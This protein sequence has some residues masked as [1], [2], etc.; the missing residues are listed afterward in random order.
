MV[1]VSGI[2]GEVGKDIKAE[3][4]LKW[5]SKFKKYIK[6]DTFVIG[7]D[8]R[9]S[10]ETFYSAVL[11]SFIEK[12]AKVYASGVISTP[13]AVYLSKNLKAAG[14]VITASHNPANW[15]GIK[16]IH[17]EG[18]FLYKEEIEELLKT[19]EEKK[20][21][22]GIEIP[23]NGASLH[24]EAVIEHS[25]IEKKGKKFKV[26]IDPVNGAS[27]YEA[28]RVVEELGFK[29]V[30][31][32]DVPHGN[33]TRPPEPIPENLNSL[34]ELIKD[35]K[36]D[37]GFAFDPD[38]DRVSVV[39]EDGTPLG[40]EFTFPLCYFYLLQR[41]KINAVIN[42]S[43]SMIAE[44]IAQ[45]YGRKVKRAPVGEVNV[46]KKM[47]EEEIKVGG[48]G[49]G[50]LIFSPFNKTRDGIFAMALILSLKRKYGEIKEVVKGFPSY[51]MVKKKI[52]RRKDINKIKEKLIEEFSYT[53]ISLEDGVWLKRE[54]CFIHVRKS[55]TEP[56]IRVIIEGKDKKE[57]EEYEKKVMKICVE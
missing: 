37:I 51:F 30:M 18:R 27:G 46:L 20:K 12:N 2:R 43:T 22:F 21:G 26:A 56:V 49:N 1:S 55:N 3:D 14:F 32:N 31:I 19:E 50:G 54:G 38:G 57:V 33:F 36:A 15:N 34:S 17:P 52:K 45:K 41:E 47:E 5:S 11:F 23:F 44:D 42:Y 24:A 39:C 28:K 9:K 7:R 48:E 8:T 16:F 53:E 25:L 10:G 35:K 4:Y 13:G 40:E 29:V 6:K